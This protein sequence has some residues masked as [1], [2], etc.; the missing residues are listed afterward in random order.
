MEESSDQEKEMDYDEDYD[1][2]YEEGD[3][4]ELESDEST[5]VDTPCPTLV[6]KSF[7]KLSLFK[8]KWTKFSTLEA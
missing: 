1:K 4:I 8:A 7:R 2:D 6:L 5:A 3:E